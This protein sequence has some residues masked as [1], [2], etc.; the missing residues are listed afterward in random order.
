MQMEDQHTRQIQTIKDS[1][2]CKRDFECAKSGFA[3]PGKIVLLGGTDLLQCLDEEAKTCRF[4]MPF[5]EVYFCRCPL[6]AYLAK[7]FLNR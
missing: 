5:G 3:K 2:K 1:L 4:A 7:H 6:R